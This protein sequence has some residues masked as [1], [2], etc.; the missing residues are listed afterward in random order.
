MNMDSASVLSLSSLSAVQLSSLV[1]RREVS[2]EEI[3]RVFLEQAK[4][5]NPE[6]SAFASIT[7]GLALR[8]ARRVDAVRKPTSASAL[9][10][11]PLGV[12]DLHLVR[13]TFTRLGSRAFRYL[14]APID[15]PLAARLRSAGT[16]FIG[17]TATSELGMSPV[18]EP[19]IHS[20]TRNPWDLTRTAGGSSGGAGSAL[21]AG[22]LPIAEGSDGAGSIRIP[23]SLNLL[24]GFKASR[25][26]LVNPHRAVDRL[27]LAVCGPIAKTTSDAA[28]ML[29]VLR[30]RSGPS[31]LQGIDRAPKRLRV[32]FATFT[33][34]GPTH[35]EIAEAVIRVAKILA[36]M[37]HDVEEAPWYDGTVDDFLPLWRSLAARA[38]VRFPAKL[39]PMTKW[40]RDAG[41]STT[42]ADVDR[43]F[44]HFGGR[45]VEWFGDVDVWLSP[46]TPILAPVIGSLTRATPRETFDAVAPLGH[47]TAIF[48]VTGQPAASVPMG[49]SRE[50]LPMGAHLVGRLGQDR[51]LLALC[52]QLEQAMPWA[53]HYASRRDAA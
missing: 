16:V 29:D 50:G 28:A 49:L 2:S 53:H 19:D 35:P 43:A 51:A 15:D 36:S 45:T 6:L 37:G 21:A 3:T 23:A 39:Q 18:T 20:P 30:E 14:V 47:L 9:W 40:L 42:D 32:R 46:T 26:V 5:R 33:P 17:K 52:R 7:E 12:K 41:Q 22:L 4:A 31:L 38:P 11:V 34:L 1:R 25:G 44:A 27:E 13:G 24:F 8:M 48:N 10:G